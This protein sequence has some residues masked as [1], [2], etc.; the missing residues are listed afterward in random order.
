MR[1]QHKMRDFRWA[2]VTHRQN[3]GSEAAAHIDLRPAEPV[4]SSFE[5]HF[6][7]GAAVDAANK[8]QADL[9]AMGVP[10]KNEVDAQSRRVFDD[11]RVMRKQERWSVLGDATHCARKVG[12]VEKIIDAC[13]ADLLA[14]AAKRQM[15]ISEDFNAVMVERAGNLVG[16]DTKVMVPEDGKNAFAGAQTA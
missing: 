2:P 4:A 11:A 14:S 7:V 9:S 3:D 10:R 5:A 8:R 1:F 15:A 12:A 6:L 16:V 13:Q